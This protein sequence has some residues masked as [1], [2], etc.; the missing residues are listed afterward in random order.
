MKVFIRDGDSWR[1]VPGPAD[2]AGKRGDLL[3]VGEADEATASRWA[4]EIGI[5]VALGANVIREEV[6]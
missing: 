1:F 6:K 4:A 5:A 3:V 2:L